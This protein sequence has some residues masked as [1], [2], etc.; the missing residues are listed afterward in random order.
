MGTKCYL[1]LSVRLD[2]GGKVIDQE[3]YVDIVQISDDRYSVTTGFL[4]E[5]GELTEKTVEVTSVSKDIL[6]IAKGFL[7]S[8]LKDKMPGTF[9]VKVFAHLKK[10]GEN[11]GS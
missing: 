1:T 9:A 2:E 7:A 3:E 11:N 6:D 8:H 10:Q 5:N 4:N